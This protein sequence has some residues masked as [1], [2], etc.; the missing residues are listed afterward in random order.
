MFFLRPTNPWYG[1]SVRRGSARSGVAAHFS[2]TPATRQLVLR[3]RAGVPMARGVRSAVALRRAQEVDCRSPRF[4]GLKTSEEVR[5]LGEVEATHWLIRV[6]TTAMGWGATGRGPVKEPVEPALAR[7]SPAR[8]RVAR[9]PGIHLRDTLLEGRLSVELLR[10]AVEDCT[11]EQ[12]SQAEVAMRPEV[13]LSEGKLLLDLDTRASSRRRGTVPNEAGEGDSR[14]NNGQCKSTEAAGGEAAG[15]T[16]SSADLRRESRE[17]CGFSLD[18]RV[19]LNLWSRLRR[20]VNM[21]ATV[22]DSENL[23]RRRS[24]VPSSSAHGPRGDG[25]ASSGGNIVRIADLLNRVRMRAASSS[26]MTKFAEDRLRTHPCGPPFWTSTE[27]STSSEGV[28]TTGELLFLGVSRR[29]SPRLPALR[30]PGGG[31]GSKNSRE[32]VSA[33]LGDGLVNYDTVGRWE[34]NNLRP[35]KVELFGRKRR[36]LA[37]DNQAGCLLGHSRV[38]SLR[39]LWFGQRPPLW[40]PPRPW[41][42]RTRA[43]VRS[44]EG[45]AAPGA[46]A[47]LT[48]QTGRAGSTPCR[49]SALSAGSAVLSSH[50]GII[51]RRRQR[52][53]E[54]HRGFRCCEMSGWAAVQPALVAPAASDVSEVATRGGLSPYRPTASN[55]ET[56]RLRA[57][58]G[59]TRGRT[60]GPSARYYTGPL[61]EAG[62]LP[63]EPAD[64][65]HTLLR[66]EGGTCSSE[67]W[68]EVPE[69]AQVHFGGE[70]YPTWPKG[71]GWLPPPEPT[72]PCRRGPVDTKNATLKN[73]YLGYFDYAF[74]LVFTG[75]DAAE[76]SEVYMPNDNKVS[77]AVHSCIVDLGIILHPGSYCR[78][79]W[80]ILDATVVLCA[81]FASSSS[82]S[83]AEG[84]LLVA[85]FTF[86]EHSGQ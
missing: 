81:L 8:C 29:Q 20:L 58:L 18:V 36:L 53:I 80:N 21:I 7:R 41:E 32:T 11:R 54:R 31:G 25:P 42:L 50:S 15:S 62:G 39:A 59:R 45:P 60:K 67:P 48:H 83:E 5:V 82:K 52:Q 34:S 22:L 55:R 79:L 26:S 6:V 51:L 64:W 44:R 68:P 17:L 74:T 73:I 70:P 47:A 75:G 23:R 16:E 76:G 63:P 14:S 49:M 56:P 46:S 61:R 19:Q 84:C 27:R 2:L 37:L 30:F 13:P 35:D 38:G 86:L 66:S 1:G 72:S 78:D 28:V 9:M 69:Y 77:A 43:E 12:V 10:D 71:H 65:P 4:S 40:I 33:R 57:R 24:Y 3:C 85:V